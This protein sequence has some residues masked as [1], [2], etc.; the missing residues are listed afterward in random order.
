MREREKKEVNLLTK[1]AADKQTFFMMK[2]PTA[3]L[4]WRPDVYTLLV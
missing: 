2:I 3:W 1:S 4:F